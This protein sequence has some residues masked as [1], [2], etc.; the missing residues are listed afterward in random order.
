MCICIYIIYT[1]DNTL[2]HTHAHTHIYTYTY[3]HKYIHIRTYIHTQADRQLVIHSFS[4]SVRQTDTVRN[5]AYLTISKLVCM[6][7]CLFI[8]LRQAVLSLSNSKPRKCLPKALAPGGDNGTEE[9][10][11]LLRTVY[12]ARIGR[13]S[14]LAS[15]QRSLSCPEGYTPNLPVCI[16]QKQWN[17]GLWLRV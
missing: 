10:E 14:Q 13:R 3:I 12:I 17:Q 1:Y 9:G 7:L 5:H 16:E 8:R 11:T 2:T 4:Q 15:L 6:Y